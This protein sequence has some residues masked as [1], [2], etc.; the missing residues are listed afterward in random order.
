MIGPIFPEHCSIILYFKT[1]NNLRT[2]SNLSCCLKFVS[3]KKDMTVFFCMLPKATY[4]G[5]IFAMYLSFCPNIRPFFVNAIHP[6]FLDGFDVNFHDDQH[7]N[8]V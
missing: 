8:N 7:D 6:T 5:I 3:M 4:L 2:A 1:N